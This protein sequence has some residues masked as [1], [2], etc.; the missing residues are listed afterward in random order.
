MRLE[1]AYP[2]GMA[3]GL[4]GKLA[5]VVGIGV[6]KLELLLV[7][8][9]LRAGETIDGRL[10]LRLEKPLEAKRL[11]VGVRATEKRDKKV[12]DADGSTR[13]ETETVTFWE[14]V[15]ELGGKRTYRDDA[16]DVHLK[17]PADVLPR[18]AQMPGGFLGDVVRAA[19]ALGVARRRPLSWSVFAVLEIPW[20]KNLRASR[21][22]VVSAR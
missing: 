10:S 19:Q 8:S 16:W 1:L 5:G 2:C 3:D 12:R 21:D 6:G 11:V 14:L 9:D 18:E 22:I 13:T 17:I 20:K 7:K 4:L 15:E